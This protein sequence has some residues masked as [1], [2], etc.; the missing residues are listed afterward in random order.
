MKKLKYLAV[1]SLPLT[2]WF[3]F[4]STGWL[5]FL[6]LI[7]FFGIV[8]AAEMLFTPDNSN[9]D[10]QER[11]LAANDSFY[12]WLL[13]LMVPLQ[14]SF[15]MYY[16]MLIPKE[17]ET[18]SIVGKTLSM[19]VMCGVIGINLGHELGHRLKLHEQFLGDL[20]LLSSLENHFV[21]YH[22][23]G[24]H[25]N[26]GTPQDPATARKNEL[27]FVFWFR[28]QIGSYFQAWQ[29]ERE[30]MQISGKSFWSL[31]NKMIQY[32][33]MHL[34]LLTSIYFFLGKFSLLAF[35]AVSML[36]ILL[37]ETVN[38]IEH[39]GLVRSQNENGKY[40]RVRRWHSW[41]SNHILGRV[42]L[43]ELSRHSDHHYKA[44]RPYQ[45]LESHE[46][47]PTMPLGYPG[48]MLM[49]LVPPLFFIVMNKRIVRLQNDLVNESMC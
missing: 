42:I 15:L 30:R 44:D 12:D 34:V 1:F 11:A 31:D 47:S 40:E 46:E 41:N 43:F 10:E 8:P 3:S 33:L 39:Y 16:L 28:S 6:P 9:L 13:Y 2:V 26:V 18:M 19:G 29:I 49:A 22:N 24:H 37:L 25:T 14:W 32:T 36:G 45:L 17:S 23:R 27:L 21:P 48:M 35:I 5:T 7:I 20:L 38:Y 4:H